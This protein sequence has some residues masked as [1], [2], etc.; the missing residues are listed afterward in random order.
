MAKRT[1]PLFFTF[2][3]VAGGMLF[4]QWKIYDINLKNNQH[5]N[6]NVSQQLIVDARNN[7]LLVRHIFSGLDKGQEYRI[8]MSEKTNTWSCVTPDGGKC[9][10]GDEDPQTFLSEQGEIEIQYSVTISEKTSP[11][12]FS[13]WT[14]KLQKIEP[15]KTTIKVID[16]ARRDGTWIAGV[17]L[18]GYKKMEF[19]DYYVFAGQGDISSLYWQNKTLYPAKI[20]DHLTVYSEHKN[21]QVNINMDNVKGLPDIPYMSLVESKDQQR[22]T[23]KGISLNENFQDAGH[24]EK[25][26]AAQYFKN[27]LDGNLVGNSLA[28]DLLSALFLQTSATTEKGNFMMKELYSHLTKE[29][30]LEL[31]TRFLKMKIIDSRLMDKNLGEI[32]GLESSFFSVNLL[33]T[34]EFASLFFFDSRE[35]RLNGQVNSKMEVIYDKDK[36]LY[37]L[38]QTMEG[39]GYNVE[40]LPEADA[41]QLDNGRNKYRFYLNRN[42]FRYNQSEYGLLE[43]PLLT[44]NGQIYIEQSGL[45]SLFKININETEKEIMLST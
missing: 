41:V 27:K 21:L 1:I 3:L 11:L 6:N 22:F 40:V 20:T 18:Q 24:V 29:Q 35:V 39:L 36:R 30:V 10:S 8:L 16:T 28:V 4:W 5:K 14:P 7:Q 19:V 31:Q 2:L 26:I 13:D 33:Q 23:V 12:I 9:K 25:E 17:P 37:P 38:S 43:N 42:S 15:I 45:Q 32:K 44:R 34:Q